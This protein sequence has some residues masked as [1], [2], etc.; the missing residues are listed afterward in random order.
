MRPQRV[1]S[2]RP[3]SVTKQKQPDLI[4]SHRRGH[5]FLSGLF[6][7]PSRPCHRRAELPAVSRA[8]VPRNCQNDEALMPSGGLTEEPGTEE[9]VRGR[10]QEG[11][12]R[13][14][15]SPGAPPASA[16]LPASLP[17]ELGAE[18]R[19][20]GVGRAHAFQTPESILEQTCP[21]TPRT[22]LNTHSHTDA[23]TR[24]P[25][26]LHSNRLTLTGTRRLLLTHTLSPLHTHSPHTPTHIHT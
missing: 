1:C 17:P 24:T 7:H 8:R 9:V 6:L 16:E 14:Q 11:H 18:A 22:V 21:V 10:A 5:L 4:P 25:T 2:L 19:V 15:A 12:W 13:Q 20:L 3:K 26:H 23:C